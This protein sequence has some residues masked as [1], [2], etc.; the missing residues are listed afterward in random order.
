MSDPVGARGEVEA[1][2]ELAAR[3]AAAYLKNID[4]AYVLKPGSE[5][6][7]RSWRSPLPEEGEGTLS[8]V[9][10]LA[11]RGRE[12]AT[13]SSGPRFFHFVMGGGTPAA[14]G[15]RLADVDTRPKRLHLGVLATRLGPRAGGRRLAAAALRASR[16]VRRRPRHR[17]D[18]GEL[19]RAC[20][21]AALVGRAAG[22]GRRGRGPIRASRTGRPDERLR[23]LHCGTGARDAR[24][25]PGKRADPGPPRHRSP[26]RRRA[27]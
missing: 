16:D 1:A 19:H 23:A 24:A 6:A 14:L 22:R 18:D 21:G 3:E 27:A 9:A 17:R 10:E 15:R 20:G 12:A 5:E 26:G 8:A 4:A 11:S 7:V 13:R 2:L 25:R